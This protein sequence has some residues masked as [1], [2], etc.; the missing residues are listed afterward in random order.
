LI[1]SQNVSLSSTKF[2]DDKTKTLT[3]FMLVDAGGKE[4]ELK[5]MEIT[6]TKR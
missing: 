2:L 4:S 1:L 5:L 6:A 3:S